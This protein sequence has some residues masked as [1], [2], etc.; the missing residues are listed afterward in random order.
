MP[1]QVGLVPLWPGFTA[2][3][4][5]GGALGC[6]SGSVLCIGMVV[7][8]YAYCQCLANGFGLWQIAK[9]VMGSTDAATDICNQSKKRHG[10]MSVCSMQPLR[11]ECFQTVVSRCCILGGEE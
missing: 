6:P 11:H 4:R 5:R 9:V 2:G 8:V 1:G 10:C 3:L 7:G